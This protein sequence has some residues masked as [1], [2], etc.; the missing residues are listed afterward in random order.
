MR[1]YRKKAHGLRLVGLGL[2]AL[3]PAIVTFFVARILDLD[4]IRNLSAHA[5]LR[6]VL[7][8]VYGW[9]MLAWVLG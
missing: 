2:T 3:V 9:L 6:F 1:R 7:A 8:L 4:T 5:L